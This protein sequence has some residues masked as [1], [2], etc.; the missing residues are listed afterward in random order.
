MGSARL[1]GTTVRL[2]F[3]FALAKQ[4]AVVD[5]ES[6]NILRINFPPGHTSRCLTFSGF[7]R[8]VDERCALLGY[9]STSSC[10]PLRTF[11][12]N[13]SVPTSRVKKSIGLDFLTLEDVTGRLSRNVDK[14]LPLHAA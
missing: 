6:L 14:E 10:N 8:K 11:R 12:D 9:Y 13:I 4:L 5:T 1:D 7:G 3:L 2:F